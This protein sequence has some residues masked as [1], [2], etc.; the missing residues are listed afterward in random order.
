MEKMNWHLLLSGQ[1]TANHL[2]YDVFLVH[3]Y[4][5][6]T[7]YI[8]CLYFWFTRTWWI[9]G[10]R[11]YPHIWSVH[12]PT[13]CLLTQ[14]KPNTEW[15]TNERPL[16]NTSK[17]KSIYFLFHSIL[18]PSTIYTIYKTLQCYADRNKYAFSVF[19]CHLCV[20]L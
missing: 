12:S 8:Y 7:Y 15:C 2:L 3:F 20:F 18:I 11:L 6:M 19:T 13:R 1:N 10:N 16:K 4:I 9:L 14:W 17:R 5:N